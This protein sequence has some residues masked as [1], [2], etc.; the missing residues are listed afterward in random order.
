MKKVANVI[1]K[2][3]TQHGKQAEEEEEKDVAF[4]YNCRVS[5]S[6][7]TLGGKNDSGKWKRGGKY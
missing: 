5:Q 6:I 3:I 2:L 4:H 1:D 7:T